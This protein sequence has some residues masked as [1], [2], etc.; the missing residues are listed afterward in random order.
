MTARLLLLAALLLAPAHAASPP[1]AS[2]MFLVADAALQGPFRESVVLLLRHDRGGSVGLI[3]NRPSDI[4]VARLRPDLPELSGQPGSVFLGGPVSPEATLA[5][6][7]GGAP[8]RSTPVLPGVHVTGG[9]ELAEHLA[10]G[11]GGAFRLYLGYA[12][13]APGQL[14]AEI[15]RG[16]WQ[17]LPADAA[18]VFDGDPRT[19]WRA[20]RGGGRREWI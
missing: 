16:G 18:A 10:S 3:V 2:G 17:L 9:A 4:P 8:P 12:G 1:P 13:W 11:A 5:L 15:A 19:L 6:V 14:E 20:L 7:R